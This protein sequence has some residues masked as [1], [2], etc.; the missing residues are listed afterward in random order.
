[1]SDA[2]AWGIEEG[3]HGVDGVWQVA[4]PAT[5]TAILGAMGAEGPEP[6][7][8]AGVWLH[9]AG[10]PLFLAGRWELQTEDGASEVVSGTVEGIPAGYHDLYRDDGR[11][12][13]LI[14]SPGRC[15]LPT[16]LRTWGWAVQL[17]ALRSA[18]SWG[19]GDLADLARLGEWAS[20]QGAGMAL[21]NPLHAPLP[22]GDPEPSPYYATSRCFRSP[23]Y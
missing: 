5:V 10:E 4:P 13:R 21:V 6:D 2:A 1:M 18:A 7:A 8:G 9:R 11:G 16:G 17:Y 23:L 3:Y 15:H 12:L 22:V 14:V 19:H 20:A